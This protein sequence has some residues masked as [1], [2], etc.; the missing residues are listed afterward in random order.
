MIP[1]RAKSWL[2]ASLALCI[3]TG[4][5]WFTLGYQRSTQSELPVLAPESGKPPATAPKPDTSR[6]CTNTY[7]RSVQQ[8]CC[9]IS[10]GCETAE[11]NVLQ[12]TQTLT[13][14]HPGKK[15]VSELYFHLYPN[16][17]SSADTTFMKESG[18]KA[19]R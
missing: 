18:G 16:A 7:C 10:H 11:G 17:F 14:T 13:W 8:P 4:G 12:G 15:T 19:S 1:R 9:G 6:K 5:I 2:T 3:L